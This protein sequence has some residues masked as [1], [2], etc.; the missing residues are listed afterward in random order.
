MQN[1]LFDIIFNDLQGIESV[2][3]DTVKSLGDV[4]QDYSWNQEKGHFYFSY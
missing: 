4:Y 3:S 2:T 1:T